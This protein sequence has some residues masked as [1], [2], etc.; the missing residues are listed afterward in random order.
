MI[1]MKLNSQTNRKL[2]VVVLG[3]IMGGIIVWFGD[4]VR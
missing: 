1:R 2:I 4:Y 3:L